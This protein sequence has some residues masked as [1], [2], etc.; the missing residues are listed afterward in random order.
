VFGKSKENEALRR[1]ITELEQEMSARDSTLLQLKEDLD[2]AKEGHRKAITNAENLQAIFANFQTFGQS[3]SEVQGSLAK[4]AND[5]KLEKDNAVK[6]QGV[7]IDSRAAIAKIATNLSSLANSS[8]QTASQVGQLDLRAQEISGIVQLIKEV[9]DQT[10]LLA[11]NAAIEAARAG[12]QGRGFAVVADEVRK[13]AERTTQATGSITSLVQQIRDE[14]TTSRTQMDLLAEQSGAFSNDGQLAAESMQN[15]LDL[16]SNMEKAVAASSLRSFCEL[17]KVDHLI[18]KFRIYKVLLGLSAETSSDFA[19]HTACR[20][21][22]WYYEG[23]GR[24]CFS[25]LPGYREVESPHM[26]VHSNA[27]R[28]LKAHG[29]SDSHTMLNS[30]S[31]MESSS[32]NVLANLEKMARSGEDNADF[33]CHPI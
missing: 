22:K 12:E 21:G 23:E 1:R 20:L 10:N 25:Q 29:E 19:S 24:A 17:A 4:L 11:L 8:Q 14:S 16:S 3:L 6:A 18:Y 2:A 30:I 7:S 9:A 32:L 15:L 27:I 33:L 31:A 5:M 28:A 26:E 13:L